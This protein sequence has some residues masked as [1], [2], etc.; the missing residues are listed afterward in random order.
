MKEKSVFVC[1][2]TFV[3]DVL[4]ADGVS[5]IGGLDC[6]RPEWTPSGNKTRLAPLRSPVMQANGV[7][8]P[9]RVEGFEVIAPDA[10][11]PSTSSIAVFVQDSPGL[12]IVASKIVAGNGAKGADGAEPPPVVVGGTINGQAGDVPKDVC[13]ADYWA[14]EPAGR[15]AGG[16]MTCDGVMN[17]IMRGGSG[18][19]AGIWESVSTPLGGG[20]GYRYKDND[21]KYAP[22]NGEDRAGTHGARG[23]NG[24]SATGY[25]SF[26]RTG[27]QPLD[28]TAGTNGSVGAGGSAGDGIGHVLPCN[29][30][31]QGG[32]V[33]FRSWG[34]AGGGAGGCGGVAGTAGRGGGAS[35]AVFAYASPIKL[36]DVAIVTGNGGAGGRGSFGARATLGGKAGTYTHVAT[37][38]QPG[39]NGG[40]AGTS[41][42]GAGGPSIGIAFTGTTP[43]MVDTTI[44]LGK[45][46]DGVPELRRD[47]GVG[48]VSIIAASGTSP[49]VETVGF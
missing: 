27:Y 49:A 13:S 2:G 36:V 12:T 31:G 16:T 24:K 18:G 47:D 44:T 38:G 23:V 17:P 34:G 46:G 3:E 22:T 26:A 7:V 25:G 35:I 20:W 41:G 40:P 15:A 21:P 8:T 43:E 9:T 1:S 33:A 45:S 28:G 5:V 11:E 14:C 19:A 10:T 6:A 32:K 37:A 30:C 29:F 4:I 42:S 39:G 48:G